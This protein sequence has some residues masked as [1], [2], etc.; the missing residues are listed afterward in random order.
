MGHAGRGTERPSFNDRGGGRYGD[1]VGEEDDR[2]AGDWRSGPPPPARE[3]DR[4]RG[5]D[6]GGSDRRGDRDGTRGFDRYEPPR[7]RNSYDRDDRRDGNRGY[8]FSRDDRGFGGDRYRRDDNNRDD[9]GFDRRDRG[10]YDRN[11]RHDDRNRSSPE[12]PKERPRLQ[13]KPRSDRTASSEEKETSS[14]SSIFGAA[15]PVDTAKKE[16]EIDQKLQETQPRV[17][18][19]DLASK[20]RDEEERRR[21]SERE[22]DDKTTT[23]IRKNTEDI[24][25]QKPNIFGSATP[26]DTSAREKEIEEKL[27]K[28]NL[29]KSAATISRKPD[30]SNQADEKDTSLPVEEKVQSQTEKTLS[31]SCDEDDNKRPTIEIKKPTS[32]DIFGSAKPNDKTRI[33]EK[34]IEE[35]MKAQRVGGQGADHDSSRRNERESQDSLRRDEKNNHGRNR[36]DRDYDNRRTGGD[37]NFDK[38]DGPRDRQTDD[39][40][41]TERRGITRDNRNDKKPGSDEN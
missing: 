9:G 5:Y 16:A 20:R 40:R 25:P 19:I 34:E 41:D 37:R 28:Q 2:T 23:E 39:K 17:R 21:S 13:L 35:K 1:R 11:T 10:G 15:K 38:R 12:A 4:D 24:K 27:K 7:D 22:K 14:K 18:T 32:S 30:D 26:V 36:I 29:S 31:R 6:R 8:G 33:R 3:N